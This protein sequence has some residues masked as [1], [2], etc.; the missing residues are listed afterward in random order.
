M[1][2]SAVVRAPHGGIRRKLT[3][4]RETEGLSM[5]GRGSRPEGSFASYASGPHVRE[6]KLYVLIFA[7]NVRGGV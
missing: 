7:C 3:I 4:A 5:V 1:A 6:I 2:E